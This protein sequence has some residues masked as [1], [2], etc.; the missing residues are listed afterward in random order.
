MSWFRS[1]LLTF[2]PMGL[3]GMCYVA[4]APT[5]GPFETWGIMPAGRPAALPPRPDHAELEQACD[6]WARDVV[7]DIPESW[8]VISRSPFVL[9]GDLSDNE[10]HDLWRRT[11]APTAR[12]LSVG[13]FDRLPQQPILLVV[14]SSDES[15]RAALTFLGHSGRHEYAG[16]YDR[17]ER[18]LVFNLST[19]EGTLAHEL[20]HALAHADF[21]EMPEWFDEGL[22]S[23]HEEC[24]FSDDGLR[25]VGLANW[26][27]EA[28]R[29]AYQR[30]QLPTLTQFV[31]HRFGSRGRT[32]LEYA[33]ARYLCL[34]LQERQVLEAFYRKCRANAELDPTG[35]WSLFEVLGTNDP[36]RADREF[37]RWLRKE[38]NL[39]L[40]EP[41][42]NHS[43]ITLSRR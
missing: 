9:M 25:L 31:N 8:A 42:A 24:Q 17:E 15:Y 32:A 13:Y 28:L 22:A 43:G 27:G 16:L 30:Q 34:Y 3:I 14:L 38:L 33:Y 35:G 4:A 23:L 37:R 12:A 18:R 10:L 2:G 41:T 36:D 11:V 20:T 21:P 39:K 1:L 6:D 7:Q 29:Q 5:P 40:V 19:G 26:R